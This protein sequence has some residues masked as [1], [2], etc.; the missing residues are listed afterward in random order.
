MQLHYHTVSSTLRA[1][2]EKILSKNMFR[3]FVLVGGTALSLQL[4]HRKS[5]DIDLFSPATY[6][7]I[8][9]SQMMDYFETNYGKTL[10]HCRP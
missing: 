7:T 3:D 8:D 1:S 6:G 4:G 9:G 2:L 5:V 10:Q